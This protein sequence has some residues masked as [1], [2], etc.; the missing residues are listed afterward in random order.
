MKML[1][2]LAGEL[3]NSAHYFSTFANVN[4]KD[5]DDFRKKIGIGKRDWH[6]FKYDLR[7]KDAEKSIQKA[8]KLSETETTK[9]TSVLILQLI[10]V[11][12]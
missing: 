2:F 6:T 10:L 9:Q 12:H 8:K 5:F 11:K 3:L 4:S 7:L 1:Y